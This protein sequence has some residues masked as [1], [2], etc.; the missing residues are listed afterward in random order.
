L[1]QHTLGTFST[2]E[3]K[4]Q[5][6]EKSIKQHFDHKRSQAGQEKATTVSAVF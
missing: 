1:K 2:K 5:R 4:L 3:D 6:K